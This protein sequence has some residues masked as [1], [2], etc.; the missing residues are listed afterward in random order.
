M[1]NEKNKIVLHFRWAVFVFSLLIGFIPSV[2]SAVEDVTNETLNDPHALAILEE[3]GTVFFEEDFEDGNFNEWFDAWGPPEVLR[4]SRR[5][6]TGDYSLRCLA[7]YEDDDSS[8]S[9]IKYWFHP[10][11]DKVH[12]RFYCKFADDFNQGWGMHFC[13]IYAVQGN[14]KWGEMGQAGIKPNGDD[15]FGTGFEPWSSW[16]SLPSPGRMQFYTYWHEMQPDIYDDNGDGIPDIHYWG[17]SFFP[18]P[19]LI[20][21][22]D[23]WYCM[24]IMIKSNDAGQDNGEMA[25]WIDGQLYM[26][27]KGFNWRTTNDLKLKRIT[28]GVYIHNNPKANVVWFDDVAL[29]SGYIGPVDALSVTDSNSQS[30]PSGSNSTNSPANETDS[31]A[32]NGGSGGC[33]ISTIE[34]SVDETATYWNSSDANVME[35]VL[36]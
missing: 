23:R 35:R 16:E 34:V 4:D 12:Y 25:A 31:G 11:Y 26:H 15:R 10:G 36:R 22:R 8:T 14:N 17:N 21:E 24:E 1:I 7:T 20:P 30:N 18:N 19:P 13:S 3:S 2:V 29:S 27:L 9:S 28:L 6:H 5:A 33:F 32:N